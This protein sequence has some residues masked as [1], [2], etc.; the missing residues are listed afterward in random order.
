MKQMG[1][2]FD[3]TRCTGCYTCA[4]ACKD[5]NDIPV[6][7][8]WRQ[9]KIIEEGTF[10]KLFLAYLS[11]SC[12][13]CID[14]PCVKACPTEAINKRE[15]DGIVVVNSEKCLGRKDC[16]SKCLK[17]CPWGIP[18]FR[19]EENAKMEKCDFCLERLEKGQQTICVEACPMFALDAA[20]LNELKEKYGDV[21]K[22]EG[23]NYYEKIKPSVIFKPKLKK[24]TL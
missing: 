6:G 3:Q 21:H 5:W 9:I 7:I 4:V 10:P 2:Y 23:F 14:P 8:D 17:V 15:F 1:F 13:H 12:H 22:A 11:T 20:P 19:V 16:G 18:Q 24:K